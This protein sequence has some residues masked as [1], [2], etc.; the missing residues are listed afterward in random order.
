MKKFLFIFAAS[1]IPFLSSCHGDHRSKPW[2]QIEIDENDC[3]TAVIDLPTVQYF[4]FLTLDGELVTATPILKD[5]RLILGCFEPGDYTLCLRLELKP[6][7]EGAFLQVIN[8]DGEERCIDFTIFPPEG[9]DP[10][11]DDED[12]EEPGRDKPTLVCNS[13]EDGGV[14]LIIEFNS[15]SGPAILRRIGD[16][17]NDLLLVED[18]LVVD[19]PLAPGE[20]EFCLLDPNELDEEG[21]FVKFA[22]C[23][24]TI[25]EP[26]DPEYE[27][28]DDNGDND[29]SECEEG[30]PEEP[31]D[32]ST[33]YVIIHEGHQ[34]VVPH[35]SLKTHICKHGDEFVRVINK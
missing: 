17:V 29:T 4:G 22:T 34:I 27:G 16:E 5:T 33:R 13:S 30:L 31:G 6:N 12:D 24:L 1:I 14:I 26:P 2:L 3:V 21:E 28:G 11:P 10:P 19:L 18:G 15:F 20:Y 25:P 32:D 9:E 7:Q 35:E 23:T 8:F